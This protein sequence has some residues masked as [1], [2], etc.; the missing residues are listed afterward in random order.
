MFQSLA[1]PLDRTQHSSA[2]WQEGRLLDHNGFVLFLY[3]ILVGAN[4]IHTA[5]AYV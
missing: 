4:L 1:D 5:A 3:S 2:N